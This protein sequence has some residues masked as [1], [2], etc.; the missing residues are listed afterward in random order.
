MLSYL[1]KGSPFTWKDNLYW[2]RAL[3]SVI[4]IEIWHWNQIYTCICTLRHGLQWWVDTK[5]CLNQIYTC[6]WTLRHGLQWWVDTKPCLNQIY[7][8]ICTLRHGFRWWVDTKRCLNQ[9]QVIMSFLIEP[10]NTWVTFEYKHWNVLPLVV[11]K[12]F[13]M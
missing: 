3:D 13:P 12:M 11:A 2:K 5:P 9:C 10:E 6:I 7:T 4:F 8:C 1:Y